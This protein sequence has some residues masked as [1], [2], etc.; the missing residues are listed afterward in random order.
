[1]ITSVKQSRDGPDHAPARHAHAH[2]LEAIIIAGL[3]PDVPFY[4]TYPAW[5]I[6][7]GQ[8]R[9]ALITNDWSDPPTW[10]ATTHHIAHSFPL[11]AVH[12]LVS[13]FLRGRWPA[14][15]VTAWSLHILI[16]LPTHSRRRWAPQFLWPLSTFT[17]DG[18]SWAEA[19]FAI[20]ARSK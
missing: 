8:L 14:A 17:F 19:A 7:T 6:R 1:M 18:V 13:R 10:M 5:V 11:V 2:R 12:A 20:V 3:A 9:H 15:E 16:D 4:L